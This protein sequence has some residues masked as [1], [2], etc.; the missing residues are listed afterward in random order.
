MN[1]NNKFIL[2]IV[3]LIG[4][5]ILIPLCMD[6]LIFGNCLE[7][8]LNNEQWAGFLGSYAGGALTLVGV[9]ITW[10]YTEQQNHQMD[11][12]RRKEMRE[13]QRLSIMPY[14]ECYQDIIRSNDLDEMKKGDRIFIIQ[15]ESVDKMKYKA[16]TADKTVIKFSNDQ[17][18]YLKLVLE[19]VGAGNAI[20]VEVRLNNYSTP[21]TL[22]KDELAIFYLYFNLSDKKDKKIEVSFK[23]WDVAHIGYYQQDT[24]ISLKYSNE[25]SD[26][27]LETSNM[28]RPRQLNTDSE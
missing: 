17:S 24:I 25:D 5:I 19:N 22:C 2:Y 15:D 16:S 14:I 13:N 8:N 1:N 3:V 26:W 27:V 11:Q 4:F 28:S 10:R 7:S 18:Y 9:F 21:Y 20:N 6:W 23:Y 12:E